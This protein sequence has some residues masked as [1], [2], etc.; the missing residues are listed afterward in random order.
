[1]AEVGGEFCCIDLVF[2]RPL[3][4]EN[5][6]ISRSLREPATS[7]PGACGSFVKE[8]IARTTCGLANSGDML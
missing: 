4:L 5:S 3:R 1:M 2:E 6:L 7:C 8:H